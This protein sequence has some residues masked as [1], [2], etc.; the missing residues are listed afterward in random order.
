MAAVVVSQQRTRWIGSR[1]LL[2][3]RARGRSAATPGRSRCG[4]SIEIDRNEWDAA[5]ATTAAGLKVNPEDTTVAR[6]AGHD[7]VAA[8]RPGRPT[9]RSRSARCAINPAFSELLRHRQRARPSASTATWQAVEL[10]KAAVA[11]VPTDYTAMGEVG[12]GYLRLGMEKEGKEW[13][14]KAWKGDAVQRARLQHA[15]PLPR[16]HRQGLR[17]PRQ[18]ALPRALQA[19]GR[20]EVLQPQI[21]PML[22]KAFA[23][24]VKRYGFTPKT[25]VDRG[26]VRRQPTPTRSARSACPT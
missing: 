11:L 23:D 18:Q 14:D 4:P 6:A 2:Q 8:R 7:R 5:E 21:E 3:G 13:L 10:G 12:L 20:G 1:M 9:K 15:Q 25:P 24:M 19:R 17:L 26:A 16:R 22:E